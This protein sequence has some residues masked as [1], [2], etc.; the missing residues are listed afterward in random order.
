MCMDGRFLFSQFQ[1][2]FFLVLC[3]KRIFKNFAAIW[4]WIFFNEILKPTTLRFSSIVPLRKVRLRCKVSTVKLSLFIDTMK[5]NCETY[6][7]K[8]KKKTRRPFSP[9]N[10]STLAQTE[11]F[12]LRTFITIYLSKLFYL[13]QFIFD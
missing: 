2:C 7:L 3:S 5:L 12:N 6:T 13:H 4:G 9:R 10:A 8:W 11:R 1:L